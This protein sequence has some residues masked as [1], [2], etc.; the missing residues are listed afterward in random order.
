M[1]SKREMA[2]AFFNNAPNS[3]TD[4]DLLCGLRTRL[5]MIIR[6]VLLMMCMASMSSSIAADDRRWVANFNQDGQGIEVFKQKGFVG[7]TDYKVVTLDNRPVLRAKSNRNASALYREMEINL[8]ETPYLNWQWRVENTLPITNQ[9][10]KAGDDYPARV[11]VVVKQGIFPWQTKALNYVWSNKQESEVFWANP[12]TA[13]AVMIPVR[14]GREGLGQWKN[15][16]VNVAE[17]FFRIFGER[18]DKADG[19]AI[20]SD[21]DN[22]RG[23][24]VAYFGNIY[25]SP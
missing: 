14:Q 7:K 4:Y 18:I 11:Y 21:T 12:F 10:V 8:I 15:E 19:V 17:D 2:L 23:S 16:R 24:A 6:I 1:V 5:I 25:F 22:S 20:M 13:K 9:K 3:S